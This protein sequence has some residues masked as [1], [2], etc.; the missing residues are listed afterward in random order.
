M[1]NNA[2]VNTKHPVNEVLSWDKMLIYGIQHVLAMYVGAV[3]VPIIIANAIGLTQEQL[4]R[5][6]GRSRPTLANLLRLLDL[7]TEVREMVARGELSAGH[8][9]ALCGLNDTDRQLALARQAM[10]QGWSVRQLEKACA[11]PPVTLRETP[12]QPIEFLELESRARAFFGAK[13]VVRGDMNKGR[14]EIHYADR[15]ELERI[16]TALGQAMPE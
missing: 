8:G 10:E 7:P 15:E 5:R 12:R 11:A 6:L 14:I 3:A 16:F 1:G 9:R 13:A 2:N 4:S